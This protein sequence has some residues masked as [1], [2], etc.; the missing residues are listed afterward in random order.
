MKPTSRTL[1][2]TLPCGVRTFLS[3]QPRLRKA[4]GSDRPVL[5]PAFS[6]PRIHDSLSCAPG[7]PS[8]IAIAS[9]HFDIKVAESRSSLTAPKRNLHATVRLSCRPRF[10]FARASSHSSHLLPPALSRPHRLIDM[11]PVKPE[12]VGFSTERLE[13]LH[14][15]IQG[16]IDNKQLC[17]RRHH[18]RAPRQNRRLPHLRHARHGHRRAHDQGHYLPRLLHDQARHRRGHDDSLRGGQVAAL[19]SHLQVHSRVRS[20]QS[21]QRLRRQRQNASRRPRSPA[22]HA[23]AH[24]PHRRVHLRQRRH[25]RRQNVRRTEGPR[26]AKPCRR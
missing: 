20:S 16:E 23:R 22:H 8:P 10:R 7:E 11:T 13:R 14:A 6:L 1:S 18:P 19:R 15:F 25:A 2:G 17:R 24:D 4:S 9:A 5:L 12:S 3:R 21:L 26:S